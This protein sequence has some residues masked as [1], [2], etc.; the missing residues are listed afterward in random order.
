MFQELSQLFWMF[1]ELFQVLHRIVPGC[2]GEGLRWGC[3][4]LQHGTRHAGC[5]SM[6]RGGRGRGAVQS[7]ARL[8][9]NRGR[10][11]SSAV[12]RP[13]WAALHVS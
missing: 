8:K 12:G 2:E 1:L 4:V 5:C 11:L 9:T 7:G 13:W 6:G 3:G 10:G